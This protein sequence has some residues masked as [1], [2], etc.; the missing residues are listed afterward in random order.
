MPD[1]FAESKDF[2]AAKPPQP[3]LPGRIDGPTD[4]GRTLNL[5][6]EQA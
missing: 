5:L 4:L 1:K 3:K 2:D 6:C